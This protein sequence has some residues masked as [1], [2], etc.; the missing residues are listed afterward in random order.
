M[1]RVKIVTGKFI[2][3]LKVVNFN[4]YVSLPEGIW[5]Y[6]VIFWWFL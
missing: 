6:D 3:L 5:E 2:S 4:D 1:A